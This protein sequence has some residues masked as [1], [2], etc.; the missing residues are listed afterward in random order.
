MIVIKLLWP[1]NI[2]LYLEVVWIWWS[3]R[4]SEW[5]LL[6][7]SVRIT[8]Q[9]KSVTLMVLMILCPSGHVVTDITVT[10]IS[11]SKQIFMRWLCPVRTELKALLPSICMMKNKNLPVWGKNNSDHVIAPSK[12][13]NW[14]EKKKILIH[15]CGWWSPAFLVPADISHQLPLTLPTL[16]FLLLKYTKHVPTSGFLHLLFFFFCRCSHFWL[17]QFF[18]ASNT[19]SE[20]LPAQAV[21]S[22]PLPLLSSSP[23]LSVCCS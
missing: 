22:H 19:S 21:G 13:R 8:S 14:Q 11:A 2:T 17:S 5:K 3:C 23:S 9:K 12:T 18:Q 10:D 7:W 16:T 15:F 4:T 1:V 20:A 6:P